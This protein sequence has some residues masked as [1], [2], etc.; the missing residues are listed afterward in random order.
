MLGYSQGSGGASFTDSATGS[1]TGLNVA[2]N[3]LTAMTTATHYSTV[4]SELAAVIN[5]NSTLQT[6]VSA[7]PNLTIDSS[8]SSFTVDTALTGATVDLVSAGSLGQTSNGTITATTLT[9]ASAG[10]TQ[11]TDA[12]S[13]ANLGSFSTGNHGLQ[14]TTNGNLVIDGTLNVGTSY[15][16][17]YAGGTLSESGA[18]AILGQTFAGTSQGATTLNGANALTYLDGFTTNNGAFAR[19]QHTKPS[20]HE[21]AQHRYRQR[22]ADDD[23]H[24][25]QSYARCLRFGWRGRDL[26]AGDNLSL[27]APVNGTTVELVAGAQISQNASGVVTATT[28]TGSGADV[29]LTQSNPVANLGAF[30]ADGGF[31]LTTS[32]NL[33]I[34]GALNI[35]TSYAEL[36][37]GGTLSES[38]S[39]VVIGENLGGSA[40]GAVTLNGANELFYLSTITI[41]SG[42]SLALT[43]AQSLKVAGPLN[44]GSGS[45]TLTTT[46]A[47]SNL[48]TNASVSG[49]TVDL[50]ASD[51]LSVY[52]PVNGTTVDLVA[53]AQITQNPSGIVTASTLTGSASEVFLVDSNAIANLGAF[54]VD[55]ALE[56]TTTGN[57]NIDGAVNVGTSFAV[58]KTGGTLSESGSGAIIGQTLG[59]NIQGGVTLNGANQLTYLNITVPSGS[60]V[61]LTNT[62]SL[63]VTNALNTGTGNVTLTTTGAASNLTLDASVSGGTVDLSAGDNLSLY[64]PVNGTTVDLVAAAQITQNPSGVVTATTLTGSAPQTYLTNSN[65]IANLGA[66]TADSALQLTTSS[67]LNIDGAVNVGTSFALL[68]AGGTLSESGSG[69]ITGLTLTGSAQGNV[70]LNGANALAYIAGFTIP[71][72][73]SFALTDTQSLQVTKAINA[74]IGSVTL[75]TTGATSN[76]S[77]GS[78][79]AGASIV[80]SAGDNLALYGPVESLLS[81]D[82]IASGQISQNAAGTITTQTLTGSAAE[83]YLTA[84]NAIANLSTFTSTNG[85]QLTTSGNLAIDGAVNVGTSF[86]LIYSGGTLGESGSGAI[87]GQTFGGSAQGNVTLNGANALAYLGSFTIPS[88]SSFALT[89]TQSLQVTSA[90]NAGTGNVTL[91]TTGA[92]SNL[93]TNA[94]VSGA[95]VDLAAGDNLLLYAPV[96]GTTVD[97]VAAGSIMQ[98]SSGLVTATTLIGSAPGVYLTDSNAIANLGAFTANSGLQL[99]TSGDLTITGAVNAGTSSVALNTGGTL[100]ETGSGAITAQTLSA[101]ALKGP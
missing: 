18:G 95:T 85:L 12:N 78:T 82:L 1:V 24:G 58:L 8:A 54:T 99:T 71:S 36:Y 37:A 23:R 42:S 15:A 68:N 17:I 6:I 11:L 10:T 83:T 70:T 41:P 62:R 76:L 96:N 31:E 2:T 64:A 25:E 51:N 22:H 13:I 72:G 56:L 79:I 26:S 53:G 101:A 20:G 33:N 28:L 4:E 98:N 75:K 60:S 65:A 61:A 67:G 40:Q 38:G 97:L 35:G 44:A 27:Y 16:E 47:T 5:G 48:T 30:T 81:V 91:T 14:L 94:A 88:G 55:S 89:D 57:L 66:F 92:A 34:D 52:A 73:S 80:L 21:G 39:G 59:G 74:G 77:T 3:T 46:G 29:F 9:G 86:A 7:L 100:G 69:A 50:S 19:R 43:D 49:G 84:S 90:L 63:Q 32:G 45:I 93:R 87:T